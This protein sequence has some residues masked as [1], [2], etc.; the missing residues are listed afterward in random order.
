MTNEPNL[1]TSLTED[2]KLNQEFESSD[3][4][5]KKKIDESKKA[6]ELDGK[7][8]LKYSISIWSDIYKSKEEIALGHPAIFPVALVKRLIEVFMRKQDRLVLD[9]FA[10]IGSTL[11]AARE[12]NKEGIGI[13]LSPE[14]SAKARNRFAQLS[15]LYQTP[16]PAIYTANAL[17]LSQYIQEESI[18]FVCTSPPYWD[19]L[20][21]K[22]TADYKEIRHYGYEAEDLGKINDYQDFLDQLKKVFI[23]VY[24]VMRKGAYCCV[25]VMDIRK[26]NKFY[27]FHS[28]IANFM[29]EIG[30]I[31]DDLIIWDRRHEYNNM[32][33]LG[34]PYVFR[35]NKAH[36][37]I[38]IFQKSKS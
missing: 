36:E 34:Y 27:P 14:F 7:T 38:L 3:Q 31:Y 8:W 33:P 10:G 5:N 32:R 17:D 1:L 28:D 4:I 29:Q 35:V 25:I 18:D 30:F 11:V 6:N 23:E 12:L 16:S 21:E 20:S 2:Q 13:E 24:K 37:Y 15:L 9:P 26:K 22:R 19:I